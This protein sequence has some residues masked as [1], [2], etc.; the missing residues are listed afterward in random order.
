MAYYERALELVAASGVVVIDNVLW[1]GDVLLQPPPDRSTAVIQDLNR[2]VA[3]DPRVTAVLVTIR[4]G[5]LVITPKGKPLPE[6]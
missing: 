3:A 4:D 2:R 6:G 1:S 5:L